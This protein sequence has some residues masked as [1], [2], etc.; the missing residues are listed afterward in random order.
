MINVDGTYKE[1][2]INSNKAQGMSKS[3]SLMRN[4]FRR[5]QFQNGKSAKVKS[6]GKPEQRCITEAR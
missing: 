5:C 2:I 1:V 4:R 3:S 6:N